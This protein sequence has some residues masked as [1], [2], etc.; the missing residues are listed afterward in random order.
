MT[1]GANQR[2]A[3][4]NGRYVPEGEVVIPFR[5]RGFKYSDAVF[6]MTRTFGHKPSRLKEHVE[7][8]RRSLIFT[9][10]DPGLDTDELIAISEEVLA[11]N[12]H[13]LDAQD[14]YWLGQRISR[15]VDAVGD[16]GW[17]HA[18]PTVIVECL[19]MPMKERAPL[20]RDGIDVIVP[21]PRRVSPD[22]FSPRVKT[23]NYLNLILG[24]L[25]AK[26][27]NPKA[28]AVLLDANGNLSEGMGSNIFLVTG[29]VLLTPLNQFVLPGVSRQAV[30]DLAKELGIEVV[31]KNLDLYDALTADEAFLTSTSLCICP[32]RSVDGTL[33]AGGRVPGP[34]TQRLIGAYI[35]LVGCD[36]VGQYLRHL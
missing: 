26:A 10:I 4:F 6:D 28:W 34:T 7:R 33:I 20:Y 13:L 5:D 24:D 30:I 9:G 29:G 22:A 1:Q 11:R 15:G 2:V 35:E 3:Y 16:E 18:G 32:I 12:L 21:T 8:L 19:P 14:D 23:H 17:D 31:E 36:F 25:K 27:R